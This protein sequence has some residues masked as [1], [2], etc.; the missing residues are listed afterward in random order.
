MMGGQLLKRKEDRNILLRIRG[1]E[2]QLD[3]QMVSKNELSGI[4]KR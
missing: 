1:L 3:C 4:H 2:I